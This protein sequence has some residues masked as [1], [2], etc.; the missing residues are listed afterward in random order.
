[1]CLSGHGNAQGAK[2]SCERLSILGKSNDCRTRAKLFVQFRE[3]VGDFVTVARF[4]YDNDH[5]ARPAESTSFGST[6][7]RHDRAH[8][9]P[10]KDEASSLGARISDLYLRKGLQ[11]GYCD[12]L[13]GTVEPNELERWRLR[14]GARSGSDDDCS[15]G[16]ANS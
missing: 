12:S 2:L 11:F 16:G 10:A 3:R 9:R 5:H 15:D 6:N 13:R 7:E 14:S 4:G 1:M 8:C